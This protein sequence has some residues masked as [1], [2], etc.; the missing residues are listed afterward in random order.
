MK[1]GL[2]TALLA[3][4][5][6]ASLFAAI[7]CGTVSDLTG[8]GNKSKATPTYTPI[9]VPGRACPTGNVLTW[10]NF[11]EPFLL[12][13]CTGC[14]SSQLDGSGPPPGNRQGAP[15]GVNFDTYELT[16]QQAIT[17][18]GQAADSNTLMPPKD[19][20]PVDNPVSVDDR[21]ALGDW[22]ACNA[23]TDAM[24]AAGQ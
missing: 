9:L 20:I 1:I 18:Y 7:G 11:G 8:Q 16:R 2:K 21:A 15:P 24:L 19:N 6:A 5:I 14:H 4:T 13:H 22:I 23:P 3:G 12:S 10:E 17:I